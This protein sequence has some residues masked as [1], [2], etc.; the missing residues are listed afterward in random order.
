MKMKIIHLLFFLCR[1]LQSS[2]SF[3]SPP[4]SL[5]AHNTREHAHTRM[6]TR[7]PTTRYEQGW[8]RLCC[9][10]NHPQI[11]MASYNKR[12]LHIQS[13]WAGNFCT[14]W[15]VRRPRLIEDSFQHMLPRLSRQAKAVWHIDHWPLN[16]PLTFHI[17]VMLHDHM[18]LQRDWEAQSY[19]MP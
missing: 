16:V 7:V 1:T 13:M 19:Y 6:H 8:A 14:L 9:D 12:F 4:F 17:P 10:N 18:Y 15:S 11:S 5:S 2:P 3:S